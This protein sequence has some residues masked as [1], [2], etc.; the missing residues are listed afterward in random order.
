MNSYTTAQL[1]KLYNIHPNTIR[2][3]EHSG[4]IS[5]ADRKGNNYRMFTDIHVQQLK[6]CRCIFGYPYTNRSLRKAGIAVMT[7]SAEKNWNAGIK[8]AARYLCLINQEIVLAQSTAKALQDWAVAS[9]DQSLTAAEPSLSRKKLANY[10]GVTVE[11]IRNWERN[12]LIFSAGIGRKKE[13]LYAENDLDRIKIINM[14]IRVGY[15]IAAIHRS[16]S[17]NDQGEVLSVS[18]ALNNPE[19]D[20]LVSAGDRWLYE[21]T[22]LG[23]AA[24]FIIPAFEEMKRLTTDQNV[25]PPYAHHPLIPMIHFE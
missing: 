15:S 12:R 3:Y 14:L 21:L 25:N 2:L 7:L 16:L 17:M 13:T 10:L 9:K 23:E 20:E 4:Y 8:A 24:Q 1:A 22:R 5:T 19:Y 11:T 6:I 18:T